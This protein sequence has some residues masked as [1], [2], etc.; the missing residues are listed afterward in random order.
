VYV[1][2]PFYS[3]AIPPYEPLAT[4]GAGV[5]LTTPQLYSGGHTDDLR[6]ALFYIAQTFPEAPLLGLGFSLG[7]NV[8]V[9]YLAEEG[10]E[11]RLQ[12]GCALGC[13]SV[14]AFRSSNS[15]T[16]RR[17]SHGTLYSITMRK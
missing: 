5:P 17:S 9:K 4:T 12:S 6:Q 14:F 8:L 1:P 15:L 3:T 10:E 11:S 13:V 16:W 7:A 2:S